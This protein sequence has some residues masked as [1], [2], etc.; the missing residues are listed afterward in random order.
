M[1]YFQLIFRKFSK[2]KSAKEGGYLT[3]VEELIK[4]NLD[5]IPK[6]RLMVDVIKL[7]K[8]NKELINIKNEVLKTKWVNDIVSLQWQDGS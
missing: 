1:R 7:N 4:N 3:T 5:S 6:H 2:I 8:D